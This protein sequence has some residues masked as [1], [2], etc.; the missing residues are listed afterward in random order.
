MSAVIRMKG[1]HHAKTPSCFAVADRVP[2]P[3]AVK[4]RAW[5]WLPAPT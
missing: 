4:L 1:E 5:P 3:N 2:Y